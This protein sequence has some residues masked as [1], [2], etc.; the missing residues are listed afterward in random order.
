MLL[1]GAAGGGQGSTQQQHTGG[2]GGGGNDVC[3]VCK[4]ANPMF[5]C[6]R[7]LS[8][9]YCSKEC[10]KYDWAYHKPLCVK[11]P[12]APSPP[13]QWKLPVANPNRRIF[14]KM[15]MLQGPDQPMDPPL[16][17]S[18]IDM[19]WK[20]R[21]FTKPDGEVVRAS[22]LAPQY[23]EMIRAG[24]RDKSLTWEYLCSDNFLFLIVQATF[25]LENLSALI[26]LMRSS[27]PKVS[28]SV[29]V[30]SII[31]MYWRTHTDPEYTSTYSRDMHAALQR[32]GLQT[33]LTYDG[34]FCDE[35]RQFTHANGGGRALLTT[36]PCG[37]WHC[38]KRPHAAYIEQKTWEDLRAKESGRGRYIMS[39]KMYRDMLSRPDDSRLAIPHS[40]GLSGLASWTYPPDE[41]RN[42][43]KTIPKDKLKAAMLILDRAHR[44]KRLPVH[45]EIDMFV[46]LVAVPK[47]VY[48]QEEDAYAMEAFERA[49]ARMIELGLDPETLGLEG[50]GSR[51]RSRNRSGSRSRSGSRP[52]PGGV[53][54]M[55]RSRPAPAPASASSSRGRGDN[56]GGGDSRTRSRSRSRSRSRQVPVA[57]VS[58]SVSLAAAA[59]GAEGEGEGDSEGKVGGEVIGI[60]GRKPSRSCTRQHADLVGM[61]GT[62]DVSDGE[63]EA[64]R[65]D[66]SND[67]DDGNNGS[68]DDDEDD[69]DED[70]D[71]DDDDEEGQISPRGKRGPKTKSTKKRAPSK[72]K[73]KPA[74][75]EGGKK[76]GVKWSAE[77]ALALDPIVRQHG[78]GS[79]QTIADALNGVRG[80]NFTTEQCKH[81]WQIISAGPKPDWSE[82]M[83]AELKRITRERW[84]RNANMQAKSFWAEVGAAL[85][86][87]VHGYWCIQKWA[88]LGR[89]LDGDCK[90]GPYTEEED[91]AIRAGK[92]AGLSWVAIGK[93]LNRNGANV[94]SRYKLNLR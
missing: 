51:S 69:D 1:G 66:D 31:E 4:K 84:D 53:G 52:R 92:A 87:P 70:E 12:A 28:P 16:E 65:S 23:K 94:K 80:T 29:H 89:P 8:A 83:V 79:F 82:D 25:P 93:G 44:D 72:P 45:S 49:E 26:S 67:E 71:E 38:V 42:M 36:D 40:G 90:T 62:L 37:C 47:K 57:S 9:L 75:G 13:P 74:D 18:Y 85:N 77:D 15:E 48:D 39:Y 33:P 5:S 50:E 35:L 63:D 32:N 10:Q 43:A 59:A 78:T 7:C 2:G 88:N 61:D 64:F 30:E 41:S 27:S 46:S 86:P 81:K 56:R 21:S 54:S 24:L 6:N 76:E 58:A 73:R 11:H 55:G 91:N 60:G 14:T 22:F 20:D 3:E 17:F 68:D 34:H 19:W